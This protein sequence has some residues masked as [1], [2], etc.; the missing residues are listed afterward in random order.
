K[1]AIIIS[2]LIF[3]AFTL[4]AAWS[5]SLAQLGTLRLL[6][7]VGIGGLLPNLIS[8]NAE[9]APRRLQAT[10][11][12]V[13]FAGITPGRSLPRPVA[14]YLVPQHGWQILFYLGGI[15]PLLLAGAIVASLPESIRFLTL[16]NRQEAVAAMIQRM[17]PGAKLPAG[18]RFVVQ[19]DE[20]LPF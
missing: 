8:L 4:A 6:A 5:T 2:Y 18:A 9:F 13:S 7:G 12:I 20:K 14:A 15:V 17:D 3:G 19:V 10:A 16:K 11:V 1:T